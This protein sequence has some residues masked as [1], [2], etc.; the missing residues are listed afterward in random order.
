MPIVPMG[1]NSPPA[2]PRK[3]VFPCSLESLKKPVA[4]IT[5]FNITVDN[6]GL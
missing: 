4:N 6:D 1:E 3:S 2:R 5:G